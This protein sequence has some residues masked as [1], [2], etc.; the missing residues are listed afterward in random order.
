MDLFAKEANFVLKVYN[1]IKSLFASK[2]FRKKVL[3]L[4]KERIIL[5][6]KIW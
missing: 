4:F 2:Y 3:L 6:K 1:R 5:R